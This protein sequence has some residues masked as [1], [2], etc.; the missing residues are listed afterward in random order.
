MHCSGDEIGSVSSTTKNYGGFVI[1]RRTTPYGAITLLVVAIVTAIMLVSQW[2]PNRNPDYSCLQTVPPGKLDGFLLE[3]T[4]GSWSWWP[5][6]LSCDYPTTTGGIVSA[7]P[8]VGLSLE[9]ALSVVTG[10][11]A[12]VL[13][14][15]FALHRRRSARQK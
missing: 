9:L 2:Y 1:S 11:A 15:R 3:A 10:A 6:G 12:I 8:G 7:G 14:V 4:T 5:T 13:F